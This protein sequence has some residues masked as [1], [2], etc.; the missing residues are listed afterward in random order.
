MKKWKVL[1]TNKNIASESTVIDELFRLRKISDKDKFINPNVSD[2]KIENTSISKKEIAKTINRIEK[3]INN[4]ERIII[5]G[6]YDVDGI[7]ASAILW[8][9]IY[10]K[11]KFV[12][13]YIPDRFSEGYGISNKTIDNL[14]KKN[15]DTKL[16]ITVDNGIVANKPIEYAKEK[17]IDVVVTDHHVAGKKLPD[18]YSIVHTTELC[19]AG[20]AYLLAKEIKNKI[21]KIKDYGEEHLGLAALATVADLVP[22]TSL[23]RIIVKLGLKELQNTRR[24]G[25]IELFKLAKINKKDL[26]VYE[27]GH[28]IGPRLNA[29]GRIDHAI[30]SLRLLCSNDKKY[31]EN[32]AMLLENT[33]RVRQQMVADSFEHAKLSVAAGGDMGKVVIMHHS[34][35]S[36]GV[37][38]LIASRLVEQYYRPSVAISVRE[39]IS[40]GSARSINGVNIVELLRSVS[41]ILS[42]VGGHPMAA[43]FSIETERIEEFYLALNKEAKK[44]PDKLFERELKVDMEIPL[45]LVSESLYKKIQKLSPF[46]MGN[47]EPA[48][49]VKNVQ[50][51]SFKRLGKDGAHLKVF[52]KK[53]KDI[54]EGI[55]FGMGESEVMAGDKIDAV[56]TIDINNW[57]DKKSLQLKLRDIKFKQI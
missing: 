32:A 15:P 38:G 21:L 34:T 24:L 51:E 30:E 57:R 29:S 8:E 50:V 16:I 48:F 47:P 56:F 10:S 17:K 35:Y 43:G 55:G 13:P 25:L 37:V 7:C 19:G 3:A 2:L 33:N 12:F 14:L 4:K 53:G 27:I 45:N 49:L 1:S 36:E 18:A 28:I 26:G 41:G 52:F 40:K 44:I 20:V 6:D 31:V 39:K 46:G 11:Y 22:L 54:I 9:T 23:N 5:L 42:E